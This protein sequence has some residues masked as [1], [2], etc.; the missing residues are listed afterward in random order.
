MGKALAPQK[1]SV[2]VQILQI[3]ENS[4]NNIDVIHLFFFLILS[5]PA[6]AKDKKN[7]VYMTHTGNRTLNGSAQYGSTHRLQLDC[8]CVGEY[9]L[10][11]IVALSALPLK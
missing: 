4:L 8:I 6:T 1:E 10:V 2:V 11:R 9:L 7:C 3:Q 5:N